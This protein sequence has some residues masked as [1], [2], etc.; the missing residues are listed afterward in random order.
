MRYELIWGRNFIPDSGKLLH[1]STPS[2][3]PTVRIDAGFVAGD[4]VSSHY[5]PMISKLIVSGPTRLAALHKLRAA[6]EAYEIAGPVTNIEFLKKLCMSPD[7][8]AGDVETGYIP[9]HHD[10]LFTRI[11]T[12]PEVFAQAALGVILEERLQM[13]SAPLFILPTS[14]V[15]FGSGFQVRELS[16]VV[17]YAD[18]KESPS[19]TR[20]VIRQTAP[21]LFDITVAETTYPNVTTEYDPAVKTLTS[22][23]PHARLDARFMRADSGLTL[24]QRGRQH[25]LRLAAPKW[26]EKALGTKDAANSVVAPMPCKV[27]RVEV[28]EGERVKRDQPLVVI[29][30]MKMETVIRSPSDGVIKRIVHRKG[31]SG[32]CSILIIRMGKLTSTDVDIGPVQGWHRACRVRRR[33]ER[34][35]EMKQTGKACSMRVDFPLR[36]EGKT[37]R[38]GQI[39]WRCCKI[40]S[41]SRQDAACIPV[42]SQSTHVHDSSGSFLPRISIL[43]R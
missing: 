42:G 12:P 43:T 8:I 29:E 34:L 24:F 36:C 41:K 35:M 31:V 16:L 18:G 39:V 28:S 13:P 30:S 9:K 15:G 5:D 22:F 21:S 19:P 3:S 2:A 38:K 32:A 23:F 25:R 10:E 33:H 4:E 6:L 17:D 7:F 14:M 27:L 11:T 40:H 26:A 1:I 20:V 37:G